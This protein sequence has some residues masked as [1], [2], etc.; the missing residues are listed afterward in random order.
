VL[1]CTDP[2]G[3]EVDPAAVLQTLTP[4]APHVT[5]EIVVTRADGEERWLRLSHAAIH[6]D[7]DL[8]RDV[9]VAHDITRE[10]QVDRLKSDFIATISHELR[11]PMTPIRGYADLLRR[12]GEDM[13]PAKRAECLDVISDRI[14]HLGRLVEDLLLASRIT[15]AM[16]DTVTSSCEDLVQ[17]TRR[18]VADFPVSAGRLVLEVPDVEVPVRCDTTRTIQV[19]GNLVSNALKYSDDDTTVNVLVTVHDD[20]A[21]VTVSD[22][23][24]GIPAD[25]LESIFDKFHR[26][27]D[28]M[29][30]TTGGTGLGLYIARR[31]ATAMNG[32]IE[33]HSQLG[34]GSSFT[35]TLPRAGGA[36]DAVA[37]VPTQAGVHVAA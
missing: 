32:T 20:Q 21:A 19:L 34:V 23:G 10:R 2:E 1:S 13:T 17:L 29:T 26:V 28:P 37:N 31:L 25:Q 11:T 14:L 5:A 12:R 24:R 15:D 7:G 8:T 30:M 4:D 18:A 22:S 16:P 35:V 6:D 9:V 36:S 27:E 33:V 3:A